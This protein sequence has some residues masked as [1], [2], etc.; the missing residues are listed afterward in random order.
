MLAEFGANEI[1]SSIV[2]L[3]IYVKKPHTDE[4]ESEIKSHTI[5]EK[6]HDGRGCCNGG[7]R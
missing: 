5:S 2:H 6:L 4:N 3:D 7:R 1:E